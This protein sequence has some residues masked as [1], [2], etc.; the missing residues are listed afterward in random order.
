V[1]YEPIAE[2]LGRTFVSVD[3]RDDEEL[4]FTEADGS[5]FVFYHSQD[6]CEQVVIEEIVGDIGDLVGSPL[7]EA[8]KA[9]SDD[10]P[11]G[12]DRHWGAWPRSTWASAR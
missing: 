1:K 8:E 6:C 7:V 9:S 10:R 2:M 3:Q 4:I 11:E 5:R 12:S